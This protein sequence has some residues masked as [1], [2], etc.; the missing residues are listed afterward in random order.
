LLRDETDAADAFS[1]FAE[2]LWTSLP[3]FRGEASLRTWA[4]RVAWTAARRVRDEAWRRR[5]RR[6]NTSEASAIADEVRTSSADTIERERRGLDTLRATLSLDEQSLL[7]LRIDQELSWA[8]IAEILSE[9][10]KRV[11]P[12]AIAKRYER[13]KERLRML[14]KEQ[15]LLE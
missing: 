11:Q 2:T 14:A 4:Y 10:G 12:A 3:G 15:G 7:V 1:E 5:G 8:E 13:L 9:T 6:L